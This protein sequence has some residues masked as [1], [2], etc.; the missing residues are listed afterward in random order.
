MAYGSSDLPAMLSDFG[1]VVVFGA[2]TSKG[3]L[4]HQTDV[5][6]LGDQMAV[7]GSTIS[8]LIQ[9]SALPGLKKASAITVG[10]TSYKVREIH[11]QDDGQ[12]ARVFLELP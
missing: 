5:Q 1:E 9:V 10:G 7:L 3:I 12:L 6:D 4:D 8:I 2:Y 11:R